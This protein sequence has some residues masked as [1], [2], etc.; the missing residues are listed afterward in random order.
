M[1]ELLAKLSNLNGVSGCEND[2]RNFILSQIKPYADDIRVD[3][4]GN[5]IA[6]KKGKSGKR[7]ILLSAH[8]DEVGFIVSKISD[9]GF[10]KFKNVGDVEIRNIVSKCVKINNTIDGI[11]GMKAIHLQKKEERETVVKTKDLYIDIGAKDKD[12]AKKRVSLG[13]YVSFSTKAFFAGDKIIGKALSSR[14]GCV[15]LMDAMK[16]EYED[17]IYFTFTA[18]REVGM[19]GASVVAYGL[20]IDMALVIDA[21]ESGDMYGVDKNNKTADTGFGVC[22]D[23]MDKYS[24]LNNT[25][26]NKIFYEFKSA[27]IDVQKKHSSISLTDAGAIQRSC[28]GV[29]T[30]CILIPVRYYHTPAEMVS[31]KDIFA[32]KSAVDLFIKKAGELI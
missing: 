26:S 14:C 30:A 24:I 22:V 16:Y 11:L 25:L 9:D 3:N 19:R 32:M 28:N 31:K 4:M 18:Q 10:I 2:V 6:L 20:D 27:N 12:E 13:D 15:C 21:V 23:F 17:N 8:M 7:N 29:L 5:I 1:V